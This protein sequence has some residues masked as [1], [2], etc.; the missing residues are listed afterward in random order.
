M[1]PPLIDSSAFRT[2]SNLIIYVPIGAKATYE[3]VRE[4]SGF[5]IVEIEIGGNVDFTRNLGEMTWKDSYFLK[6]PYTY[7]RDLHEL[8]TIAALLSSHAYSNNTSIINNNVIIDVNSS[9][10]TLTLMDLGFDDENIS[11]YN[12]PAGS[13]SKDT[14][15]YTFAHKQ[16]AGTDYNLIA[17]VVRGTPETNEWYSNFDIGHGNTHNGFKLAEQELFNSLDAYITAN[18]LT[19]RTRNKFFITGHSR[20]AAVANLLAARLNF[21]QNF[22]MRQNMFAFT[23]ATPNV[24]KRSEITFPELYRNTYNF[25]NAEDFV[26]YLPLFANGWDFWKYGTTYVIPNTGLT[27]TSA[28]LLEDFQK[29]YKAFTGNDYIGFRQFGTTQNV[30]E[31]MHNLARNVDEFYTRN[32][33]VGGITSI[34]PQKYFDVIA[35]INANDGNFIDNLGVLGSYMGSY[36]SITN[37]FL[38]DSLA[39]WKG[40]DPRVSESHDHRLYLA[41][42]QTIGAQNAISR[43]HTNFRGSYARIACPVDV[44]VYDSQEQLV[45]KV[46]GGVVDETLDGIIGVFYDDYDE[47][48]HIYMPSGSTYTF[49]IIATDDGTMSYTMSEFD[50]ASTLT[51]VE[52]VFIDIE[53][54]TG[55]TMTSTVGGSIE[56]PETRLFITEDGLITNEVLTDGTEII[57]HTITA[58]AGAGGTVTGGGIFATDTQITLTA[59]PDS[60]F[61]FDGWFEN[62]ARVSDANAIYSFAAATRRTLEARFTATSSGSGSN[63][64]SGGGGGGGGGSTTPLATT[65]IATITAGISPWVV[66]NIPRTALTALGLSAEIPVNQIRVPTGATGNRS[67]AVGA[68]YAG[69][70]AV[71]VKFNAETQQL[72]FVAAST[73]GANGN[74]SMSITVAGDFLVLTFKTGDITGTGEVQTTDALALLRHVAGVSELNSIQ[75]YVANG[76]SDDINTTDALNI[77]RYVAGLIDRI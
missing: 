68:D 54:F 23:F 19:D 75:M 41:W 37:Y 63:S 50:I 3:A 56:T 76:K 42:M 39:V 44:E 51:A 57:V 16:L 52:K 6:D 40:A 21:N 43:L 47:S 71:L 17:V 27:G 65:A 61:R 46:V 13:A 5:N 74:A 36:R 45:G 8:A 24:I 34:A 59:T 11:A 14:V 77:L 22:C 1:I 62:G 73:V 2:S 30:I 32:H 26:P 28:A 7:D 66:T 29:R 20:G 4:L 9:R 33:W 12:Y 25:V 64:S 60:N 67:I 38:V 18:G 10:A 15:G 35:R 58:T 53:L 72:E 31:R 49:I 69:Q 55:K 70:N 48:T